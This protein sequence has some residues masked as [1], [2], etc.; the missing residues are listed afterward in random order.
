MIP[1]HA[2]HILIDQCFQRV[3]AGKHGD[4]GHHSDHDAGGGER[5]TQFMRCYAGKRASDAIGKVHWALL[6]DVFTFR[7]LMVGASVFSEF[8]FQIRVRAIG[9]R[10]K[11]RLIIGYPLTIRIGATGIEGFT[12][13][14]TSLGD[15]TFAAFGTSDTGG[16]G[17]GILTL[18]IG[19]A[20]DESAEFPCPLYQS[21][22]TLRAFLV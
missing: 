3:N 8:F 15:F 21:F 12:F 4:H 11:H 13:L 18:R 10:R 1:A 9:A 22:A 2:F 5:A 20:S 17:S 14:A 6:H 19:G 7:A 16:F